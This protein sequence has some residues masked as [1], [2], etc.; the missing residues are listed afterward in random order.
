[1]RQDRHAPTRAAGRLN[2]VA[3]SWRGRH[4]AP[5]AKR[6]VAAVV[7]AAG[8]GGAL[9]AAPTA[10]AQTGEPTGVSPFYF[11]TTVFSPKSQDRGRWSERIKV[12]GDLN[13]DGINDLWV[14][15][16]AYQRDQPNDN[17][18]AD[19]DQVGRVY[20]VDG[21]SLADPLGQ[22][23]YPKIL[24]KI[25]PPEPQENRR[26]GFQIENLG[27]VNADGIADIA[28]GTDAQDVPVDQKD[29]NNQNSLNT[30]KCEPNGT[31]EGGQ[32]TD[33]PECNEFQGKA[34][35]FDGKTNRVLYELNN[36]EPQGS[37]SH[38]ARFGSRLG[39]AGDINGD[40]ASEVLAGASNNDEPAG[41]SDD[42]TVEDGCRRNEGRAYMFDG[43]TGKLVRTFQLP[44]EDDPRRP[45]DPRRG[46]SCG[47]FGLTVQGPGDVDGD[48]VP[49]QLVGAP[50][51]QFSGPFPAPATDAG[52]RFQGR[53]Y[54]FSGASG[55]E[56]D[57][58]PIRR[59]DDPEPQ[60]AP[61]ALFGF[62]DVTPLDPGDVD[63]DGKADIYGHGFQQAGEG[64]DFQG[65]SWVFNGGKGSAA[66]TPIIY[67]VG[68]P[69]NSRTRCKSFGWSMSRDRDRRTAGPP[70]APGQDANNPILVGNDPHHCSMTPPEGQNGEQNLFNPLTG[71]QT[72][73]A[74]AGDERSPTSLDLPEPFRREQTTVPNPI[75]QGPQEPAPPNPNL[76]PNLGWT[77]ASPGDLNADGFRDFLGGA[78]FT[79]VCH[80]RLG[81]MNKEQYTDEGLMIAFVSNP[82]NKVPPPGDSP[83]ENDQNPA[84]NACQELPAGDEG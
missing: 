79:N 14:A 61:A 42:G 66:E 10:Q 83:P 18:S 31:S 80:I 23:K 1:M 77:S 38:T 56:V 21:R 39:K 35:V 73:V 72:P 2:G 64:G 20:A 55:R 29:S 28:V 53:L 75:S 48:G 51:Y 25:N 84:D 43:K 22:K 74:G 49:D 40:G 78:P 16:P 46:Q 36:P 33:D 65:K 70:V 44:E 4:G 6:R 67:E 82:E 58:K 68:N 9:A 34:W 12:A 69:P 60:R 81:T 32:Q 54:V 17:D 37:P 76:G 47:N 59:I 41:C 71:A 11:P 57:D 24:Y 30:Q 19:P 13:G 26:F 5:P 3:G 62:E 50:G 27:D 15:V 8:L 7:L 63:G 45:C 52:N